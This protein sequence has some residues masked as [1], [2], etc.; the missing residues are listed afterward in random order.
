MK[1][2]LFS[3][4]ALMPHLRVS[5]IAFLISRPLPFS[6]PISCSLMTHNCIG[7]LSLNLPSCLSLGRQNGE[8]NLLPHGLLMF[9]N[10]N[11]YFAKAFG[12]VHYQK[13]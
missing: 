4:C 7:S 12:K 8:E 13:L 5:L 6:T 9:C 2:I 3:M 10:A 11:I 1:C